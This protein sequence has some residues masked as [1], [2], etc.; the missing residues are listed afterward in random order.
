MPVQDIP[1]TLGALLIGGLFALLF[2]P[3]LLCVVS[4]I[5]RH[6]QDPAQIK[7]LIFS[8]W[9]LDNLHTGFI[10]GGLWFG[11]IQNYGEHGMLMVIL[12]VRILLFWGV[13]LGTPTELSF[14]FKG[15][16]NIPCTL[17]FRTPNILDEQ[18]TM[19]HDLTHV[20]AWCRHGKCTLF[21]VGTFYYYR[22]H[23]SR[24]HYRSYNL[25]QLH[26]HWIFTIGLG[27]SS[28]V[29]ILITGLLVYLFQSN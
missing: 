16:C 11:S 18:E 9:L 8:V 12:T 25:F 5:F 10:W 14:I 15:A 1:T 19:A 3:S 24:L 20:A 13:V 2:V 26:A 17:L 23:P 28:A 4:L 27:V 6:K 7:S 21:G 29:D 22:R